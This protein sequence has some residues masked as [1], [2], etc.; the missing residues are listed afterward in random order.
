MFT[1]DDLCDI[2]YN[3]RLTNERNNAPEEREREREREREKHPIKFH[4]S[5]SFWKHL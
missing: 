1:D 4:S 3:C 5:E 2:S